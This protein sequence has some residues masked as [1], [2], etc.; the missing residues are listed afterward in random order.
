MYELFRQLINYNQTGTMYSY[1]T[2]IL[3]GVIALACLLTVWFL[4]LI[5]RIIRGFTNK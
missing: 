4:D 2:Y 5:V 1:E 3:Y